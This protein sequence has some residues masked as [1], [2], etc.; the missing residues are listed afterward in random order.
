M[1]F[2]PLPALIAPAQLAP[3]P[4]DLHG[5]R[6]IG[7]KVITAENLRGYLTFIASDA[8]QGRDTPSQGLDV[9]AEFL[10]FHLKKWGL[11]PGGDKGTFFQKIPMIKMGFDETKS[12]LTIA[13]TAVKFGES[14]A[15]ERGNGSATGDLVSITD[16]LGSADVKG[17][18]VLLGPEVRDT[19]LPKVLEAG[20]VAVLRTSTNQSWWRRNA[21]QASRRAGWRMERTPTPEPPT[22][23][24]VVMLSPE[25]SAQALLSVGKSVSVTVQAKIERIYTQ[26]VVAIA[27]GSDPKLKSEFVAVG[28]HYDH[29]G[30]GGRGTDTIFNGAD[31]DG[32]GTVAI[33]SM[34]EAAVQARP[35][36][37]LLFVW[38]AGEE[39]GLQGSSYFVDTPTVPIGQIVAQLNIDMIGRSKPAGDTK[40]ANKDLSGPNSIYVIGTTM[41]STELGKL[42]HETNAKYLKLDYDPKYDAPDD[43]NRFF[44]RSD[45]FNYAKKGIPICFWFDGV[46]E[47]YHQVGDEVSK[48]DFNKMEKITRT[49]FLTAINIGNLPQ[50]PKVDKP[51]NR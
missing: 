32:S 4:A 45:H 29:V 11:K 1:L 35:K 14:F 17:K 5:A 3:K 42:I 26:N 46:H 7:D 18:I 50:R 44:Y 48:I 38:H 8:L 21:V 47:D 36:R 20:A 41:M 13:E 30:T 31:D 25:A 28:A 9:A 27:E 51:L 15:I 10:A 16:D 39:K 40:P 2:L 6:L 49:V 34:A 19:V 37:S 22:A 43:P 33:L 24:P 12:S 23:V